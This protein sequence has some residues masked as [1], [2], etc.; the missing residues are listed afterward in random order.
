MKGGKL[1]ASSEEQLKREIMKGDKLGDK[2]AVAVKS[3][4]EEKHE[5][6]QAWE[7]RRQR[8]PRAGQK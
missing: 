7:T 4:P 1:V 5:G 3:S 2:A 8:Q 6:R